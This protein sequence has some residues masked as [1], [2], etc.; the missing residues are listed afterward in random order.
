AT[1]PPPTAKKCACAWT[2]QPAWPT[3]AQKAKT[4]TGWPPPFYT[5]V[6][7]E[8]VDEQ[9]AAHRRRFLTEQGYSYT[10]SNA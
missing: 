7:A 2:A 10:I 3:R 1:S 5:V 9:F 8:T 4:A 6:A